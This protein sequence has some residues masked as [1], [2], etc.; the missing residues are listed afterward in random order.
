MDPDSP[1]GVG[2][3]HPLRFETVHA[4]TSPTKILRPFNTSSIR[5]RRRGGGTEYKVRVDLVLGSTDAMAKV[6]IVTLF[7]NSHHLPRFVGLGQL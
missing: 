1:A 4:D 6:C 7:T 5:I 3:T 2:N